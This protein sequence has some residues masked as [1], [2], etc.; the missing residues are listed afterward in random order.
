MKLRLQLP[1]DPAGLAAAQDRIEAWL[2][3]AGAS[4]RL[5]Y[6]VRLVLDELAANLARHGR[7]AGPPEPARLSLRREAGAL[8]LDVE[9][10]AEPFDPRMAAP[11]SAPSLEGEEQGG[12]GLALVGRMA[13]ILDYQ[14]LADGW[15]RLSLRLADG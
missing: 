12:R 7:F 8:R 15:N 9:D 3:A 6:R 10:A 4:L 14:R 5:R 1:L 2:A 11:P 13:E